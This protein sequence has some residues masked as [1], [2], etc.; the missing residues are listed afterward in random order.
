VK[1]GAVLH[2]LWLEWLAWWSTLPPEFAFLLVLP[3]AVGAIGL[4]G[5]AWRRRRGR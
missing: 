3:F 1:E 5:D 4:I 2:A